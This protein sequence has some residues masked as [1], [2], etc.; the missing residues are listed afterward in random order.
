MLYYYL[1]VL[2]TDPSDLARCHNH[3]YRV[4]DPG[5]VDPDPDPTFKNKLNPGTDPTLEKKL[6]P[7]PT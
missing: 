6:D 4:G 1:G 2:G 5:G 3:K 7:D